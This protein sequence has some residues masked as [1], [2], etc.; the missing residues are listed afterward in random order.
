M[1]IHY[2]LIDQTVREGEQQAGVRFSARQKIEILH[3]LEEFGIDLVEVG[4]PGI[5]PEDEQICRETA[6]A[7]RRAEILMHARADKEEVRAAKR[8]GAHWVGIWASLNDMALATKFAGRTPSYVRGK[9]AEAIG[10]AKA[11]G[12]MVRFTIEDASRTGWDAVET[13]GRVAREAGADRISLA[14]TTGCWEPGQCGQA[15]ALARAAF[16]CDIEV[17]LHDDLGLAHANA[18]AAIDAGAAVIDTS[19]LGIGERAGITNS[20]E[21]TVSLFTLRGD[22]RFNL[23]K[24][25]QLARAIRLATGHSPD[26]LRPV[27]GHN[28]FTHSSAYHVSAVARNPEAYE[29]F[30]P[31]L[32]G[33]SRTI[34]PGRPSLDRS[35]ARDTL[36]V[37][38]PF[39][40]GASE[41]KYHRDGP[42]VRWVLMDSRVDP[43]AS[44]YVIQRFIGLHGAPIVPE[45]HVDSHAH[46]CDSLF[47]FWG[48]QPDGTGLTCRIQLEEETKTVES[49]ASIFIPAEMEHSYSYVAGNGTYTNIVLAPDYNRSLMAETEPELASA[50]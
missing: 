32:V 17:H 19:V 48:D 4:H 9:I 34:A 28:A 13:A 45:N 49:P 36:A 6:K 33:R 2:K 41:L 3:L 22:K 40:K 39:I 44:F 21:L 47:I 31:H 16:G 20:L 29:A 25:P 38:T 27:V 43:R 46:H 18:L 15:V 37:G 24:I 30:P 42:G 10:E 5:S 7:A 12:L 26:S 1:T 35:P 14:D 23:G 50:S 11:L 8:A